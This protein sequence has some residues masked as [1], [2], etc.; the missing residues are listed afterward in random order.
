MEEI[1]ATT[2]VIH[3]H[4][5]YLDAEELMKSYPDVPVVT[6]LREP[7]QRVISS[8]YF[9]KR[10]FKEGLRE[11]EPWLGEVSLLEFAASE[12]VQNE[13][14]RVLK[15]AVLNELGFIGVLEHLEEDMGYLSK[16]LGWREFDIPK[17]NTNVAY[18]S[19]FT[20]PTPEELEEIARLNQAD[21]E[22]YQNAL[23]IRS[24]RPE[25]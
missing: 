20:P 9:N 14:S 11:D 17:A 6:W 1:P 10:K 12:Y 25:L 23:A 21:I 19:K 22:L 13:M 18:K 3:G 2:R 8:Y 15:G 16:M 5:Y 24:S 7:V 4:F